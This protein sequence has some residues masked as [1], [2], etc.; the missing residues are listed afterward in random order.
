MAV[1]DIFLKAGRWE[2]AGT[3]FTSPADILRYLWFKHTGFLQIYKPKTI[4][5]RKVKNSRA[6]Y[7]PINKEKIA[8]TMNK[9]GVDA[10]K[11]LTLKFRRRHCRWAASWLNTMNMDPGKM[12][13]IMHPHRGMWVRFIRALR[14]PEYAGKRGFGQ[15]KTLLD[16]FYNEK[17]EV[18]QGKL[19]HSLLKSDVKN[20][21]RML[22]ERPGVFARSLFACMLR[23]G[24]HPVTEAFIEISD[25]VPARLLFTLHMYA[26]YYFNPGGTRT[27]KPLGGQNKS[28]PNNKLL[29]YYTPS[30]IDEMK[31]AVADIC[32]SAMKKRYARITTTSKTIFIEPMLFRMPVAIG[33]RS[34]SVQDLPVTLMGT[35]FTPMGSKVRLFMQWGGGL[36]AQ[37][38]DMDLSC[39]IAFKDHSEI[40]SYNRLTAP[41]C[42]HSG[43]IRRIPN[44]VGTAEYIELDLD[45]LRAA[46]ALY[47]TFTCNAYSSGSLSPNLVV[48]WMSSEYPMK[49]SEKTGVA[50]DPSCVQHQV[51]VTRQLTK[52]L[53]FGVLDVTAGEIIWLEMPF[54]GQV[55]RNLD[56]NAVKGMLKKLE[57]KLSIGNLLLVK[58]EAQNLEVIDTPEADEVYDVKWASNAAAITQ[59]LID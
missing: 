29:A 36:P 33:D 24:H 16:L 13:E 38:L 45:K 54:G 46:K 39:F 7:F 51:R 58:A 20:S 59:L 44:K 28:I 5:Q 31:E 18:W 37:H 34:E 11:E 49:I 27:V 41:G 57:S 6:V 32:L 3:L 22:K 2:D 19:N 8:K 47:V 26:N 43:D 42:K 10:K 9:A 12:C 48:G 40:C 15:L 35:R 25:K 1:I 52:G 30:Q 55:V 17:Y 21:M 56:F 50:Y 53:V 14:L 4:I 23:F